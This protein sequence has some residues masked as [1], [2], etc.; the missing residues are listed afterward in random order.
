[1]NDIE[2][3]VFDANLN[4]LGVIDV[5]TSCVIERHYRKLG[6]LNLIV[7]GSN[8]NLSLLQKGNIIT[9]SDD[10]QRGY[11]IETVQYTEAAGKE[12]NI[13]ATS[14]NKLLNR[15]IVLGQQ[16]FNG[17]VEN[18]MKSFVQVNAVNPS[19]TKR[20]IPNLQI[21]TN[22][23]IAITTTEGTTNSYLGDYLY[24]IA[25]KFDISFDILINISTKKF[26]FTTWQGVDRSTQQTANSRIIFSKEFDNVLSQN[27]I[28]SIADYKTTAIVAGEGEGA[29]RVYLTVNDTPTGLNRYELPVDARDIQSTYTDET[30]TEVTLTPA[31]YQTVLTERGKNKLSEYKSIN[32]FESEVDPNAQFIYNVDYKLGDKVSVINNDLG[33]TMHTRIVSCIETYQRNGNS[34]QIDFGD[35]IPSFIDKVKRAVK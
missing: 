15:R 35:N 6:S 8:D 5:Y 19:N 26:V 12:I 34:L 16:E 20:I 28:D 3:Y 2:L 21:G 1:M 10:L 23:G 31:E 27:Y 29:E 4:R 13:I 7:N 22:Q 14:L 25:N 11:I 9:K 32:T 24:E 33:I 18:V 30:N 17:N